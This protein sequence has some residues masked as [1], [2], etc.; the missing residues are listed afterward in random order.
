MGS[1]PVW[2][3][4]ASL[5]GIGGAPPP[6][7]F[8][9]RRDPPPRPPRVEISAAVE[10]RRDR[11]HYRFENPSSFDTVE[12][13]PHFFRQSYVADNRWLA[14]RV[15][16][17]VGGQRWATEV[18]VAPERVTFGDD[19]DTFEQP[20][21]DVVTSGTRGDVSLQSW[22]LAQ[23]LLD[24]GSPRLGTYVRYVYRRDRARFHPADRIVT[25]TEPP[26]ETRT[27]ITSRETTISETHELQFG[28]ERTWRPAEVWE[29]R[30]AVEGAPMLVAR[31]ATRL[32]DKYPGRDVVFVAFGGSAVVRLTVARTWRRWFVEASADGERA[33]SYLRGREFGRDGLGASVRAGVVLF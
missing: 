6:P 24:T 5:C 32:P 11:F 22:R 8:A 21:G 17:R 28:L 19:F 18:A 20:D 7:P 10:T 4:L 31:L 33:W 2:P 30:A 29:L 12:L 13:V 23:R 16:Y 14:V 25:H 26:S 15:R 1:L 27:F 3:L 9:L